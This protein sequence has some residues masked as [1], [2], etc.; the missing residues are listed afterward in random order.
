MKR[1][2]GAYTWVHEAEFE[3]LKLLK[4]ADTECKSTQFIVLAKSN[5]IVGDTCGTKDGTV[6]SL[7]CKLLL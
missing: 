1:G 7:Q 5:R 3:S 6:V 4:L 2:E